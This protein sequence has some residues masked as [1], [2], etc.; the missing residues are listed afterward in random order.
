MEEWKQLLMQAIEKCG[1]A[2]VA[3]R[4]GVDESTISLVARDK[5]PAS[6]SKVAAKVLSAFGA[7][8]QVQP[9]VPEGYKRDHRGRLVPA[10]DISALDHERD[11]LVAEM[12]GQAQELA[13]TIRQYKQAWLSTIQAH[14]QLAAEQYRV[15]IGGDSGNVSLH[16]YDGSIRVER[17]HSRRL[18][19]NERVV[20]AKE[21]VSRH[22]ES[23]S[24][25]LV[26][27]TKRLVRAAFRCDDQGNFSASSLLSLARRVKSNAPSWQAA[28]AAINDAV[29]T[30]YGD[31][32]VR[33][34]VREED[35]SFRQIPLDITAV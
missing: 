24:G 10:S 27:E 17:L 35:G 20:V 30:E 11:D 33:V 8:G 21:L 34:S 16:A 14:V 12:L 22:V 1:Q 19:V 18:V 15:Q 6:T 4:I 29:T 7:P 9:P 2:E 32:Y 13:A 31:P 28:V 26:E 3:R 23:L 25:D 5:Y